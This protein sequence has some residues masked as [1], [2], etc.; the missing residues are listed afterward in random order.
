MSDY[1]IGATVSDDDSDGAFPTQTKLRAKASASAAAAARPALVFVSHAPKPA[2]APR[3]RKRKATREPEPEPEAAASAKKA[4][5][6]K[7]RNKSMVSAMV[8]VDKKIGKIF[9]DGKMIASLTSEEDARALEGF[10]NDNFL[11]LAMVTGCALQPIQLL[12]GEGTG[13][14][15]RCTLLH[16]YSICHAYRMRVQVHLPLAAHE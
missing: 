4:R 5:T 10:W 1:P 7:T 13:R 12:L 8:A 3:K 15:D 2:A 6:K 9:P 11:V 16:I 14:K